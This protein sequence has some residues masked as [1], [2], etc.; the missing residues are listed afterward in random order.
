MKYVALLRGIN[1]G[2]NNKVDMRQL[3]A[4]F[5]EAG[6]ESVRT[7]INSGNILFES[8]SKSKNALA[9]MLEKAIETTFGFNVKVLVRSQDDV[10]EI[11]ATLPDTWVND[12]TMKT[13]IMFLWDK[14]ASETVLQQITIKPDL[15][16]VKYVNGTI[17][18]SVGRENITRSGMLRLIGTELYKHMTIRNCNTV[19]KIAG[20]MGE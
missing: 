20:M 17:L 9:D 19:R 5:E 10:K 4:V 12:T 2:G 7:Y 14:V 15:D 3:K 11:V 1:V 16:S 18:W 13:D 8:K 6:M